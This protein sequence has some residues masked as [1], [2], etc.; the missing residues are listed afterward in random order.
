MSRNYKLSF[1]LSSSTV[2]F[3]ISDAQSGQALLLYRADKEAGKEDEIILNEILRE[4]DVLLAPFADARF[5][6]WDK[7]FTLRPAENLSV[8][9]D[10]EILEFLF[11]MPFPLVSR[12]RISGKDVRL[13]YHLNP[14]LSK[15]IQT[16][17]PNAR[18]FH[19]SSALLKLYLARNNGNPGRKVY[20]NI[21]QPYAEISIV[22]E[23]KI[24]YHNYFEFK[25]KEDLIYY[26]LL[27]Y[28]QMEMDRETDP[29]ILSGDILQD[30]SVYP[31][32]Y[33]FIGDLR[34]VSLPQRI[35]FSDPA[36]EGLAL[37]RYFN[38]LSE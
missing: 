20:L 6:I 35:Q 25:S 7:S 31:M 36:F 2:Q 27:V 24:H 10:E 1:L 22:I 32:L 5:Y 26:V 17:F 12:D 38:L 30:S 13:I 8:D 11:G 28:D 15:A 18:I 16:Q 34:F 33:K 9:R 29:L 3:L 21:H 37:H 4:E 14:V 23:G 19:S